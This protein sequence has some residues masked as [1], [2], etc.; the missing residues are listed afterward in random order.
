M[1]TITSLLIAALFALT[2]CLSND[3]ITQV[4][5]SPGE[6]QDQGGNQG[7]GQTPGGD[8]SVIV[9]PPTQAPGE[10][11]PVTPNQPVSQTGLIINGGDKMTSSKNL[12]LAFNPPFHV[13][14]KRVTEG[15][16]C[17][18]GVWG[19]Y[20]ANQ[21][22]LAS[23]S[24]QHVSVS[25]Q[26]R[27]YD[28]RVTACYTQSI[29]IDDM[30]PEIIFSQYPS[31]PVELG[32]AV[33]LVFSVSDGGSGVD[34]V[35]CQFA[36]VS[37]ECGAGV[38][39]IT[40]SSLPVGQY[41][42]YVDARDKLGFSSSKAVSFSVTSSYRLM[43]Q[44]VTVQDYQK[45]DILFVVDNSGSMAYEQKSMASRIR[46]F[47]SVVKGLDWQIAVTTT[48]PSSSTYGDGRLVELKGMSGQY[49]LNSQMSD[50]QAQTVLGNTL[51]RTETGSSKEQGIYAAYRA[52]ERSVA[53]SG[54]N[55]NFVRGDAQL[56]VVLISDED[57]SANGQ[58]NDPANFVN[59]IR[60]QFMGQKAVTYH[61]IIAKP[62]DKA[63]LN[64][65]GYSAGY[66]YE[67]IS[68]LTGGVI[69]DVCALD[70]ADQVKGIAE[71]VRNTLKTITLG[72]EPIVTSGMKIEIQK[73]GLAYNGIFV[74]QGVNLV[75]TEMLPAGKYNVLYSCLK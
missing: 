32:S 28:G 71:G 44:N 12:Q 13:A 62:G 43:S 59:Y 26:F 10:D 35:S 57:E 30:G 24:N 6:S 69:G 33:A 61:S 9:E 27:D 17:D 8:F 73:D 47:L 21:A 63:C 48:D 36:G 50:S 29:L 46:N 41:T 53:S 20:Q 75:F 42:F 49:I 3:S 22:F 2:G 16:S 11:G 51:Q 7:Q 55:R 39:S 14:Y 56:A 37:K 31:A 25:A 74:V 72:C 23:L 1:R 58:K 34:T 60:D 19:D 52:V 67:Q 4:G 64:G 68:K 70:Y 40:F 18:A 38:N 15:T 54:T 5:T 65:E 66:R 45:V